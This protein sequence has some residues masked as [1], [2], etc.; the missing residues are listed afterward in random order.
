MTMSEKIEPALRPQGRY[1][2]S[3]WWLLAKDKNLPTEVLTV[4]S[5][6]ERILPAFSGE[7]EAEMFLW[8]RK[9]F[10]CGWH[11][12]ETSAGEI[13]SLLSGPFARVRSVA[14]DPSPEMPE[15]GTIGLVSVSPKRFMGQIFA[16]CDKKPAPSRGRLA[17]PNRLGRQA[18][19]TR[20][21]GFPSYSPGE[22]AISGHADAPVG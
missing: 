15:A 18:P 11:T 2:Y 10:E 16:L 6:G 17:V 7:G 9:A 12:R 8:L 4:N 14:L 21:A 22:F 20:A 19:G 3:R 13:V 1:P 5:D